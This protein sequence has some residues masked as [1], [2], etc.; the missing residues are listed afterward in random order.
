MNALARRLAVVVLVVA[1]LG[2]SAG[3]GSDDRTNLAANGDFEVATNFF[4]A[5]PDGWFCFSSKSQTV[6]AGDVLARSGKKSVMLCGQNMPL[7]HGGLAQLVQIKPGRAYSFSVYVT[8]SRTN[9]L[10]ESAY[11]MIG[12]EW[13][14]RDNQEIRRVVSS[15]WDATL[16]RVDWEQY[17][18]VA[19]APPNA[20]AAAFVIYLYDGIKGSEGCCFVDD[21][22][23][24]GRTEPVK[25]A[26]EGVDPKR[27]K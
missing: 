7:G 21:A 25:P 27:S 22:V 14:N 23:I 19:V 8:N 11:G 24:S 6:E 20:V 2:P 4:A 16:S 10:A 15:R 17:R 18:V 5:L 26:G 1:V 12:I 9:P 3:Y 13:K